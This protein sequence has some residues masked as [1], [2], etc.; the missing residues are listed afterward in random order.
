MHDYNRVT[1][2]GRLTRDPVLRTTNGGTSVVEVGFASNSKYN[3][4][5]ETLYVDLEFWGKAAEI[6]AEHA[7]KG[8]QLLVEGKLKMDNWEKDGQKHTKLYVTV[9]DFKFIGVKV[10]E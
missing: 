10:S 9:Q 3:D 1:L 8:K 4:K 7:A 2:T 6:I 5:E